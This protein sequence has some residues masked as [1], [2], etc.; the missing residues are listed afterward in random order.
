MI[1]RPLTALRSFLWKLLHPGRLT[2]E[3]I[4]AFVAPE[5]VNIGVVDP[6]TFMLSRASMITL[7]AHAIRL[8]RFMESGADDSTIDYVIAAN[9]SPGGLR[10]AAEKLLDA[11][12]A[13]RAK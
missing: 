7:L 4:A 11:S 5:P 6:E 3:E 9:A 1:P 2:P 10:G 12:L 8:G 13:R